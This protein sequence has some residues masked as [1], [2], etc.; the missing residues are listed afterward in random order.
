M[1]CDLTMDQVLALLDSNT[2]NEDWQASDEEF[3]L[4]C[5]DEVAF[6]SEMDPLDLEQEAAEDTG[7]SSS[8][9][10]SQPSSASLS[11]QPGPS[12]ISSPP[13]S[14]PSSAS[15]S[16]QP[17]PSA[18]SSP[19]QS[20]PSSASL[21]SQPGPSTMSS[22][23]SQPSSACLSSQPRPV[24]TSQ[25]SSSNSSQPGS[26]TVNA[27]PPLPASST[28]VSLDLASG[29]PSFSESFGPVTPLPGISSSPVDFFELFFSSNVIDH[30]V[31]Q[32]NLYARQ[33]P[34]SPSYEWEDCTPDKMKS[35][36]GL[37]ILMGLKKVPSIIGPLLVF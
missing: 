33:K 26:S 3:D 37:S 12:A 2:E 36:L 4:C 19:P 24:V 9:P 22:P 32:T 13:Q 27:S 8:S 6:T 23:P 11:S 17:G 28:Q 14:Q 16:S 5:D 31:Q 25:P 34:P 30:I 18:M 21:S 7:P 20:Q 1:N 35:F 15:L 29:I 10:Q